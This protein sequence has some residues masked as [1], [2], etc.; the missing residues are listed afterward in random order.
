MKKQG[1]MMKRLF[2]LIAFTVLTACSVLQIPPAKTFSEK[3]AYGV[4][5]VASI[6]S[7]TDA[8][9]Q[10]DVIDVSKARFVRAGSVGAK[11]AMDEA[12]RISKTDLSAAT[13]KL[14]AAITVLDSLK[15]YLN[16]NGVKL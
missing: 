1:G 11:A 16:D 9:L 8:A 4:V 15:K 12:L 7:T 6:I 3:Y 13:G 14:D 2:F 10:S 5:T